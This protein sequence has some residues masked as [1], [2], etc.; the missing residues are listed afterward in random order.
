M[1]LEEISHIAPEM[2]APGNIIRLAQDA[3]IVWG[4]LGLRGH[5]LLE[6]FAALVAAAEREA[7]AQVCDGIALAT[8][9]DDFALDAAEACAATIRA[10]LRKT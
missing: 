7:C 4:E 8:T 1:T 2:R 9:P 3:G 5:F 10:R 6:R